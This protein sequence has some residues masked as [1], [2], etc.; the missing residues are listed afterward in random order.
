MKNC[1]NALMKMPEEPLSRLR[2]FANIFICQ[3]TLG[4]EINSITQRTASSTN[5][6]IS[7]SVA[8]PDPFHFGLLDPFFYETDPYQ[9]ET[10]KCE[11][12]VCEI[13]FQKFEKLSLKKS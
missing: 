4:F 3:V 1:F 6:D 5:L 13:R 10:D 7:S 8:D 9:L 12:N 11:I 2:I